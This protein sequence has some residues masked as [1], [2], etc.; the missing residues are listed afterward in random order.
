M[1]DYSGHYLVDLSLL[2]L[3]LFP[4]PRHRR[5]AGGDDVF[6]AGAQLSKGLGE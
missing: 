4:V 3:D 2:C 5:V 1:G 6:L